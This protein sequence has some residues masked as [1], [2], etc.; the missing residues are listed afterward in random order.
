M[1][2]RRKVIIFLCTISEVATIFFIQEPY[3]SL[4][5]IWPDL[6]LRNLFENL[7]ST[8]GMLCVCVFVEQILPGLAH[9]KFQ[10]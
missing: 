2:E 7:K 8:F 6:V 3:G 5:L 1:Q 9:S 10:R 4:F